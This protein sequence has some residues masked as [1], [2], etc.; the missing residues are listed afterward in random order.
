MILPANSKS[1][2]R[3]VTISEFEKLMKLVETIEASRAMKKL[4]EDTSM[5]DIIG[6]RAH[7]I[8]LFLGWYADGQAG[9]SVSF[10]APGYK[11]NDLR[12]YNSEL[13][14]RQVGLSW[15]DA[16]NM[17]RTNYDKLL[18]FIDGHSEQELYEGP[19]KGAKNNW[20]TGR[21]VE[22]AG[23]SHFRSASKYLRAALR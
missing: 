2:L 3:E 17:L 12:R 19:M 11:W 5:K 16:V 8:D 4:D 6:H 14:D 23:A 20:T 9:K 15:A 18:A 22:A 10:P 7:W 21:W 13:R 1:E